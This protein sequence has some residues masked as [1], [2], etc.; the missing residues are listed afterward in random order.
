M[1][2][3]TL[4]KHYANVFSSQ[5]L[6][7]QALRAKS[8]IDCCVCFYLFHEGNCPT[9]P[10]NLLC[11]PQIGPKKAKV[12][13]N[14]FGIERNI[15]ED[16]AVGEDSHVKAMLKKW[17]VSACDIEPDLQ[18]Q[19]NDF[20]GEISQQLSRGD[21]ESTKWAVDLLKRVENKDTNYSQ[22]INCWK[23]RYASEL[24]ARIKGA[25]KEY[26]EGGDDKIRQ[27]YEYVE[28]WLEDV[29][30]AGDADGDSSIRVRRPRR[31]ATKKSGLE[32]IF[33]NILLM[34]LV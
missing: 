4:V 17:K 19:F 28:A 12:L 30:D 3:S 33:N 2:Y 8:L 22:F 21:R 23:I 20:V 18:P 11:L 29:P 13:L 10:T 32:R 1:P 25:K 7:I 27:W 26:A 15:V 31:K 24:G 34:H 6:G 14:G 16:S 5:N 9:N